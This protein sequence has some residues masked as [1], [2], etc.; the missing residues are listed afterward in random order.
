MVERISEHQFVKCPYCK[1][2]LVVVLS[3]LKLLALK[4]FQRQAK[5]LLAAQRCATLRN[6]V[7]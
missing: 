1:R 6:E 3:E 5:S 4:Q 2:E 7:K